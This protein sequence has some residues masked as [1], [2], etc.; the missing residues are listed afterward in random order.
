MVTTPFLISSLAW[1]VS[2][3]A[4]LFLHI[5]SAILKT[6]QPMAAKPTPQKS[7]TETIAFP[8]RLLQD[9]YDLCRSTA[10]NKLLRSNRPGKGRPVLQPPFLQARPTK[11]RDVHHSSLTKKDGSE[12]ALS[13]ASLLPHGARNRRSS[14]ARGC[15]RAAK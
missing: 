5:R 1:S 14:S 3:A 11:R 12:A 6:S 13:C 8:F 2:E 15:G 10:S 9:A 7:M 4:N